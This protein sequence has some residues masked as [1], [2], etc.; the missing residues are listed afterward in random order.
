MI[1]ADQ[2]LDGSHI[3]GLL[4]NLFQ[5]WWPHLF[6]AEGFLRVFATPIVKV[7]SGI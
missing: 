2:D 6:Q 1:M 4:V 5:T 3:K 7:P